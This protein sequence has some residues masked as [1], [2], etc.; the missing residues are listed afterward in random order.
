M[1]R[2]GCFRNFEIRSVYLDLAKSDK[3]II[4]FFVFSPVYFVFETIRTSLFSN[5]NIIV[6]SGYFILEKWDR[7]GRQVQ[8]ETSYGFYSNGFTP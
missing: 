7:T 4:H 8:F 3:N 5:L 6:D 1:G 2:K